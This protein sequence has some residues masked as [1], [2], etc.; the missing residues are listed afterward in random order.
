MGGLPT[1]AELLGTVGAGQGGA[2][3]HIH[4]DV[5]LWHCPLDTVLCTQPLNTVLCTQWPCRV[6]SHPT[7]T[8]DLEGFTQR[9]DMLF[10]VSVSALAFA[11]MPMFLLTL[12]CCADRL[13]CTVGVHPTRT[14]EIEG[15][16]QGA[17]AYMSALAAVARRGKQAGKV[18]AIGECGLDYDRWAQAWF[19]RVVGSVAGCTNRCY[20]LQ[21]QAGT[22]AAVALWPPVVVESTCLTGF[23]PTPHNRKGSHRSEWPLIAP[24][25]SCN[26]LLRTCRDA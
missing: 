21:K 23:C 3:K 6:G 17:D 20:I 2:C 14:G 24:S 22:V 9:L 4:M 8:F 16:V 26:L 19:I 25:A 11:A 5:R 10:A 18:V 13:F 1:A 15:H 12:R 7:C